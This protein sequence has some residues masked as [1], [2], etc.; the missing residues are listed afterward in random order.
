MY[1]LKGI[2]ILT[3]KITLKIWSIYFPKKKKEENLTLYYQNIIIKKKEVPS[4][5]NNT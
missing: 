4:I 3:L 1:I 2:N 5:R